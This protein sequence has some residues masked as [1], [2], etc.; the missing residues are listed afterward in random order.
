MLHRLQNGLC[1]SLGMLPYR[2]PPFLMRKNT[3]MSP[4]S[5]GAQKTDDREN[6]SRKSVGTPFPFKHCNRLWEGSMF[7]QDQKDLFSLTSEGKDLLE[8]RVTR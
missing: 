7:F 2:V 3:L 1:I 4:K 6:Q 5:E 8:G